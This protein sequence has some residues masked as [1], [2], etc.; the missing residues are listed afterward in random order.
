MQDTAETQESSGQ[1]LAIGELASATGV[2]DSTIRFWERKGLLSPTLRQGGQRRYKPSAVGNVAMLRLCQEAGFTLA[3]IRRLMDERAVT[4]RSWRGLVHEKLTD[5]QRQITA[6]E[7]ARGLL[8]HALDCHHDDLL[9]CPGFRQ[10]FAT[11]VGTTP[12]APG[13]PVRQ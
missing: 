12:P 13:T 7:H 6:L 10:W 2:P 1:L 9:A 8:T 5:V 3:D 11:H 4:P